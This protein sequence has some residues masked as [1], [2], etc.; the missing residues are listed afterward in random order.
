MT[1]VNYP[2]RFNLLASE[3]EKFLRQ[4]I[5]IKEKY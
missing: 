1:G 5:I 4:E 2:P 3:L